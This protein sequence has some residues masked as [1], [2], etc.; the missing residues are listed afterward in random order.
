MDSSYEY[1]DGI[2]TGIEA[3]PDLTGYS[4]FVAA[5]SLSNPTVYTYTNL[6]LKI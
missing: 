4:V 2:D 5:A 6:K 3:T 1:I